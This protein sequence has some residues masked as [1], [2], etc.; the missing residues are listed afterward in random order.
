[1]WSGFFFKNTDNLIKKIKLKNI[2]YND[3]NISEYAI[4]KCKNMN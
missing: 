2:I 1:M 4:N 3:I